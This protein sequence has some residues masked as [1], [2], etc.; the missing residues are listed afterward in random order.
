[1]NL[2]DELL[3]DLPDG[4]LRRARI[5]L[6]WTGVVAETDAGLRCGLASTLASP[7]DHAGGPDLPEAGG[8]EGMD[9]REVAGWLRSDPEREP[10]RRSVGAA[11]LNALLPPRP[12]AWVDRNASEVIAERGEGRKVVLIGSFPFTQALRKRVGELI[13]LD[14]RPREGA[15]PADRAG[16]VLP[17]ADVAAITGMTL[18]NGSLE[19]LLRMVR[20]EATVLLLGPSTPLSPVLHGHGVDLLSG[21]VVTDIDAVLR[22]LGQGGTF[23]QIHRAG[24]RLVTMEKSG[25]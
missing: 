1:M 20:P 7:H 10:V 18:L 19:A 8:I 4:R 24:V 5:G 9:A 22:V 13:V 3:E 12:E 16:D 14:R 11:A 21:S 15:L 25:K 23:R 17:A 2:I 6:H